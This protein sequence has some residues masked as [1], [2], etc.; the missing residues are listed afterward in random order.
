MSEKSEAPTPKRLRRAREDGDIAKS[1]H[2]TIAVSGLF[3]W[4]FLL[5][6]GAQLYAQLVAVIER[7]CALDQAE[8]FT[9]RLDAVLE[10]VSKLVGPALATV[11]AGVLAALVPE[12]AQTRGVLAW[13]R[14]APDFK[15]LNPVEGFKK[16][17]GLK[18]VFDTGLL[19]VQ[20][21]VLLVLALRA[22]LAC[23]AEFVPLHA[24]PLAKQLGWIASAQMH[25]LALAAASMLVPASVDIALQ[26]VLWRR[27]LKMEKHE[28]KRE[29][30][31]DEGDPHVKGHR[32]QLQRELSQ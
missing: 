15:R 12:L 4:L 5:M 6:E 1:A 29:N 7:V 25:F 22:V 10:A 27:R 28:V 24:L 8:R 20:L 26:R 21:F 19:L 31:D 32:R 17:F 3:W 23:F 9:V 30:R 11:G 2:L 16:L 13:K 14:I 18:V